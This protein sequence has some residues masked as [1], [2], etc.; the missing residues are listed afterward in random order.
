[1]IIPMKWF[2][3]NKKILCLLCFTWMLCTDAHAQIAPPEITP[4]TKY[5]KRIH[6]YREKW[7]GL[8]PTYF[9]LQYAGNMGLLSLGTGWDYGKRNQWE[10]D[11]M[12]GVLPQYSSNHTKLTFTLKQNYMPWSYSLKNNF[13]LEPLA[14]GLYFNTVFGDE[15]W[16]EEP[17]RYPKGYYGF[18]SKIR[19]H[20]F[21]GQRL[22]YEFKNHNRFSH[23]RSLTFFYELSTCDLYLVSAVGNNYLRPRDYLSLSFGLKMQVF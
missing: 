9:K 18:S 4:P 8:I 16:V 15:F 6:R 5:D 21:L 3:I 17:D 7:S 1:M 19:T 2:T 20:V 23:Y 14:C 10:T 22:T 11:I 12:F 13:S